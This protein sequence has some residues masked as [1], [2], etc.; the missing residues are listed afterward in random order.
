[1]LSVMN[2][3]KEKNQKK[4]KCIYHYFDI[5]FVKYGYF[6]VQKESKFKFNLF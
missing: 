5:N 4:N 3:R 2:A 6:H 1:M